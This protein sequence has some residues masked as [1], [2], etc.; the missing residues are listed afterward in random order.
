MYVPL[1]SLAACVS[2]LCLTASSPLAR[3]LGRA[4][5]HGGYGKLR[6]SMSM[7]RVTGIFSTRRTAAGSSFLTP[8]GAAFT[9][10]DL[11]AA[12]HQVSRLTAHGL[13]GSV[14]VT[15]ASGRA[16]HSAD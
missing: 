12:L 8:P 10:A 14:T 15:G 6:A 3:R 7:S 1:W 11:R 4:L 5:L 9:D 2:A 13:C 16:H